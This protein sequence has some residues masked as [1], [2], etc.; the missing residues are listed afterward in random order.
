MQWRSATYAILLSFL[1][2]VSIK[3]LGCGGT[4]DNGSSENLR[5]PKTVTVDRME[6]TAKQVIH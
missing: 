5:T 6:I 1:R 3:V 2:V 4:P